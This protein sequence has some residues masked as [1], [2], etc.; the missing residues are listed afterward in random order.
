MWRWRKICGLA[1][2]TAVLVGGAFYILQQRMTPVESEQLD[3]QQS[4]W[5]VCATDDDCVVASSVCPGFFWSVN[6]KFAADNVAQNAR[7]A[8]LVECGP[9]PESIRP[10][11]PRCRNGLCD[12]PR[13]S[14]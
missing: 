13:G 9:P 7:L 12:L 5:L 6:T 10:L 1:V 2:V 14:R 3:Y 4:A 8:A 11:R